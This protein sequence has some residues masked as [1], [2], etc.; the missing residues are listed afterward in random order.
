MLGVTILQPTPIT[1]DHYFNFVYRERAAGVGLV[2]LVLHAGQ[3]GR[4]SRS[5]AR[6]TVAQLGTVGDMKA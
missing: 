6:N 4:G 2:R 3:T 1:Y 5:M